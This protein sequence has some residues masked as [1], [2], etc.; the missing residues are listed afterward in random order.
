MEKLFQNPY[1]KEICSYTDKNATE[2][3]DLSN[4]VS[5]ISTMICISIYFILPNLKKNKALR[6]I[7]Y[8]LV[9]NAISNL[10]RIL[11]MAAG[12]YIATISPVWINIFSISYMTGFLG[13]INLAL[14]FS[15]HL[16]FE[17]YHK[18]SLAEFEKWIF[19][20]CFGIAGIIASFATYGV[21][22]QSLTLFYITDLY[23]IFI[24]TMTIGLY[25]KVILNFNKISYPHATQC[26]K[27]LAIYPLVGIISMVFFS[28][29]Q[30]LILVQDCY[31][32]YYFIS[33]GIRGFQGF[34][35]VIVYGFNTNVRDEIKK[36][37]WIQ[38]Q[39]N[40]NNPISN[41]NNQEIN[42]E[43]FNLH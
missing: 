16:Y 11:P 38:Q 27:D 19:F 13:G 10:G 39:V 32:T 6:L 7:G 1:T 42:M 36:R 20:I 12:N 4:S 24:M 37:S 21:T 40:I 29:E 41:D 33:V 15:I 14:I 22:L 28:I 5:L 18:K 35:D 31:S 34:I 3:I 23:I 43:N 8:L 25:I 9:S 2:L 30:V 26:M 17:V